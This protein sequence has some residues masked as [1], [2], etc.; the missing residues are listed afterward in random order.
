MLSVS[1]IRVTG[2]TLVRSTNSRGPGC[3]YLLYLCHYIWSCGLMVKRG[4]S[5]VSWPGVQFFLNTLFD[6]YK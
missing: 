6:K 1:E 4:Y 3:I 2:H 5:I